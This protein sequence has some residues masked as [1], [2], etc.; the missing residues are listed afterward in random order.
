MRFMRD[1]LKAVKNLRKAAEQL[2]GEIGKKEGT[3]NL[4][5]GKLPYRIPFPYGS[6]LFPE[7]ITVRPG[8]GQRQHQHVMLNA[9][10]Q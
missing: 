3:G 10:D 6:I 7:Q 2:T 4:N 1:Q 9:V 8:A 5:K